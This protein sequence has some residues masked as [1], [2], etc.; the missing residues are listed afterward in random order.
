MNGI[1][2]NFRMGKIIVVISIIF[3]LFPN[4]TFADYV[5]PYPSAMPGNILYKINL[6]KDSLLKFWYFGDFGQFYYHLKESDKYL[7]ET[8]TLFEYKQYLLAYKALQKSDDYF[9][10]T[11]PN[12]NSA[13]KSGKNIK[14]DREILR[15]AVLKHTE[16]LSKIIRE[17]PETFVWKPEKEKPTTLKIKQ[18][19]D[20]SISI[21]TKY[22]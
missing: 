4:Y 18:K 13:Q 16:I 6:V 5:L 17:V 8:K 15:S 7:V 22:L 1:K 3:F 20:Q 10:K 11:L 21:R 2:I 19:I 9:V 12:L 14:N